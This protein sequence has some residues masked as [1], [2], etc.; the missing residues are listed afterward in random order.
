MA[1]RSLQGFALIS[2]LVWACILSLLNI[3]SLPGVSGIAVGILPVFVA[4]GA[5]LACRGYSLKFN[6][7]PYFFGSVFVFFC[8]S[9]ALWPLATYSPYEFYS[10]VS[11]EIDAQTMARA[12]CLLGMSLSATMF[13]YGAA[14][15][16]Q[17]PLAAENQSTFLEFDKNHRLLARVGLRMM[18]MAF[19]FVAYRLYLELS[20]ILEAGYLAL[21]SEG[22]GSADV[23]SWLTPLN[24]VFYSG[25]GL[26]CAFSDQRR[27]VSSAIAMFLVVALVDGMKGARGA[28]IVPLLFCWWFYSSRFEVKLRL[29]RMVMYFLAAL[30]I[31]LGVT[32][33][34]DSGTIEGQASQF[35]IDAVATQGRSL[36]LTAIYL[37]EQEEIAKFGNMMVTSNLMIPINVLLHPELR[38][39]PQSIDQVMYS[40]NLKHIL[41]Y[42]LNPGYYF[43][44]GG[45]GGVYLIELIESGWFLFLV[46]SFALGWFLAKWPSLMGKPYWRFMAFQIFAT[47]FYMPRAELFPN[48]LNFIKSTI[49]F[50]ILVGAVAWLRDIKLKPSAVGQAAG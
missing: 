27:Q 48:S 40:N 41:T 43:E 39:L 36:Q 30:G 50:L 46:L 29:G 13:A 15:R 22:L 31:F 10:L 8:M 6:L 26:V 24:Y 35:V 47:V 32:V 38:D 9:V 14:L 33:S 18:S 7:L 21:Y 1:V 2:L 37:Q 3:D 49:I 42:T 44:G 11:L 5:L 12:A 45:T 34:R 20:Y 19:P 28:V 23:P 16:T 4:V 17:V 25:F